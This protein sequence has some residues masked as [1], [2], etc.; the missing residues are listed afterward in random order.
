MTTKYAN[1]V[2]QDNLYCGDLSDVFHFNIPFH[3]VRLAKMDQG[4]TPIQVHTDHILTQ[5]METNSLFF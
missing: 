4:I 5:V 2:Q 3:I 1:Q